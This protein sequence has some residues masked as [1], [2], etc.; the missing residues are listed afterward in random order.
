VVSASGAG[1]PERPSER[2][3]TAI[4]DGDVDDGQRLIPL[5]GAV[6]FRDLG[7]FRTGDGRTVRWRTLF[8]S[9]S[10]HELTPADVAVLRDELGV[11]TVVDLRSDEELARTPTNPLEA[12]AEILHHPIFR[13]ADRPADEDPEEAARR[14]AELTLAE[15]YLGMFDR[16]GDNLAAGVT[17]VATAPGPAVFHC[18]AGKDRTGVMAAVLLSLLGVP[19]PDIAADYAATTAALPAIHARLR[20]M[21]GY[22]D[23]L[24]ELPPETMHAQYE[25][26]EHLLA[27]V[28]ERWGSVAGWAVEHGIPGSA[29]DALRSRVL[30]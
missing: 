15:M 13:A 11:V 17:A 2:A 4:R 30:E 8:R 23:T 20:A 9:D 10:L 18:A 28:A 6:N 27:A 21:P 1:G 7:G 12:V 24:R 22:D 16:L 5:E 3:S 19:D 29:V 26:M 25:T 14:R